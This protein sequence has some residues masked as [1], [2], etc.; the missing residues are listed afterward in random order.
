MCVCVAVCVCV[1]FLG[2]G[3][4]R[5]GGGGGGINATQHLARWW[6]GTEYEDKG[7]VKAAQIH[8]TSRVMPIAIL[9]HLDVHG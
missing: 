7:T 5:R 4:K 1:V 3:A 6:R 2:E 8:S 9:W